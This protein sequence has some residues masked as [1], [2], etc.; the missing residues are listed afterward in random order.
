MA[1]SIRDSDDA[2]DNEL[3]SGIQ[4][5]LKDKV[6]GKKAP[7]IHPNLIWLIKLV[8]GISA[9]IRDNDKPSVHAIINEFAQLMK[10]LIPVL[11]EEEGGVWGANLNRQAKAMVWHSTTAVKADAARRLFEVSC[12]DIYWAVVDSGIDATH[13]AFRAKLPD[14][15]FAK[16]PFKNGK[17][18]TDNMTRIVKTYDFTSIRRILSRDYTK[19]EDLTEAQKKRFEGVKKRFA[20]N[21]RQKKELKSRLRNG[22]ALDWEVLAPLL[23]IPHTKQEYEPPVFEHGT[24]VAGILAADWAS[25]ES[26]NHR[27]IDIQGVCPDLSL[28]DMRVLDENGESDEF[29][30]LAALQFVLY[31]T[32]TADNPLLQG[33][34][35]SLSIRHKVKNFACGCTPVCEEVERLV[36]SGLIVVAAAGNDG[37]LELEMSGAISESYR[38]ISITDPGNAQG[39]ITVVAGRRLQRLDLN[40][41]GAQP[42]HRLAYIRKQNSLPCVD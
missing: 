35:I 14:G 18:V 19:S 15:T 1:A 6:W 20:S 39:V 28:Y 27:N 10:N 4:S 21:V 16:E 3:K 33:V 2:S 30:I 34:N 24:H 32:A 31:L 29:T 12:K 17:G 38:S 13:P 7:Q 37:Y 9:S 5:A 40:S 41:P 8:G 25:E 36:N 42:P 26:S 23:E 22:R 11:K